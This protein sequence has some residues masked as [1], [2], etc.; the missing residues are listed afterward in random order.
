MI[1]LLDAKEGFPDRGSGSGNVIVVSHH[2][3][4]EFLAGYFKEIIDFWDYYYLTIDYEK[5]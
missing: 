3:I 2:T 5:Q 1:I 4:W